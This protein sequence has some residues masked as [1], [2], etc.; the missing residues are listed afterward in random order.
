MKIRVLCFA[1]VREIVGAP[2]LALEL[3]AGTTA[4]ALLDALR[5]RH[6]GL[7]GLP[8]RVAVERAFVELEA[9]LFD[10]AEVALIPPVAGG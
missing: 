6:P 8:L 2:A 10:G 7:A 3:P 4:G 5:A 9:P 1:Q